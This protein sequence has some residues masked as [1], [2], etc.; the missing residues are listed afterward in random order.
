M[1]GAESC[2][3]QILREGRRR[4]IVDYII[5]EGAG[6]V[7]WGGKKWDGGEGRGKELYVDS[8]DWLS[9]QARCPKS[10]YSQSASKVSAQGLTSHER[11]LLIP[12]GVL[13][14]TPPNP[15]AQCRENIFIWNQDDVW[16]SRCDG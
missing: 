8:G 11:F 3:R 9:W 5:C 2:R 16:E 6:G 4:G 15:F 10:S 12:S 1:A 7:G 14:Q 13:G